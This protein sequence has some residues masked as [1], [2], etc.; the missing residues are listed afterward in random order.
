MRRAPQNCD[1]HALF[2]HN[3]IV[4]NSITDYIL[5]HNIWY[6]ADQVQI[7]IGLKDMRHRYKNRYFL[8]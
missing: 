6:N 4:F 1:A 7:I 5:V 8:M 3:K 2:P